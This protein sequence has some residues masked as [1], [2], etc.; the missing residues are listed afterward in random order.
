[1]SGHQ[2]SVQQRMWPPHKTV[3][4]PLIEIHSNK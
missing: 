4:R 2:T 1:M 3:W